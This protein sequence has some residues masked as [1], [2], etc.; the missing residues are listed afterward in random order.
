MLLEE[1]SFLHGKNDIF[2][3]YF[4]GILATEYRN[5]GSFHVQYVSKWVVHIYD[6]FITILQERISQVSVVLRKVIPQYVQ[7]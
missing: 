5:G 7:S 6:P 3:T 2:T 1:K 4:Y